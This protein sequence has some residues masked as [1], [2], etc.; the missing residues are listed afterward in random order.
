MP[1]K[2]Q[3]RM[4]RIM[5]RPAKKKSPNREFLAQTLGDAEKAL[6]NTIGGIFGNKRKRKRKK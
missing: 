1:S 3:N 2:F 6:N 5:Y 4:K